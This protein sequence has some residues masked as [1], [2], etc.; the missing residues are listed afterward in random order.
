MVKRK[1]KNDHEKQEGSKGRGRPT[2]KQEKLIKDAMRRAGVQGTVKQRTLTIGLETIW[3]RCDDEGQLLFERIQETVTWV[4]RAV[5]LMT[6]FGNWLVLDILR[7]QGDLP[8]LDARW[9]LDLL[10]AITTSH[11]P[12]GLHFARFCQA[13]GQAALPW[14]VNTS[15]IMEYKRN[16]MLTASKNMLSG[17]FFWRRLSFLRWKVADALSGRFPD[18]TIAKR[19]TLLFKTTSLIISGAGEEANDYQCIMDLNPGDIPTLQEIAVDDHARVASLRSFISSRV[20][21]SW[22]KDRL[23]AKTKKRLTSDELRAR[24]RSFSISTL[25]DM[26]PMAVLRYH[27][28]QFDSI[29]HLPLTRSFS[30]CTS[31]ADFKEKLPWMWKKLRP[32]SFSPLPFSS[33]KRQFIRIDAKVLEEA[34]RVPLREDVWWVENL[35]DVYK[36]GKKRLHQLKEYSI[37]SDPRTAEACLELLPP[38]ETTRPCLPGASFTTDG[39]S[40]H[41]SVFCFPSTIDHLDKL[42]EA[43]YTGV[44]V[45]KKREKV[46]LTRSRR[47]VHK[48]ESCLLPVDSL[49]EDTE[50]IGVDPGAVQ[51]AS[52][53]RFG[54]SELTLSRPELVSN[55]ISRG[56]SY[57]ESTYIK[58][59]A[60]DL[61]ARKEVR[62]REINQR[63]RWSLEQLNGVLKKSF[64]VN[65]LEAYARQRVLSDPGL[66]EELLD[67][68]RSFHRR[69]RFIKTQQ[70]LEHMT[71][72]ILGESSRY[73]RQ[74]MRRQGIDLNLN[75]VVFFGRALFSGTKGHVTVPRKKLIRTLACK[76]TVVLV[77][78]YNTSKL[79]PYDFA[80]LEDGYEKRVRLCQTEFHQ[81]PFSCDR[82]VIGAANIAQKAIFELLGARLEAFYSS[83]QA[84]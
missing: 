14:M 44:K 7:S 64:D 27:V 29:Q 53:T 48:L 79:C 3:N 56:G 54:A 33:T 10:H 40:L 63:Y 46:D 26:D 28:D 30:N 57:S 41:L 42:H 70:C 62:R 37:L 52:Y 78:E 15:R 39:V 1:R 31:G 47:G 61:Q 55:M 19:N 67:R 24:F 32:P 5:A 76:A 74:K 66:Q 22:V 17:Q 65:V 34:W 4:S 16:E 8:V 72:K 84:A 20:E 13:T 21:E 6:L 35:V 25:V 71:H 68:T 23:G 12:F 11:G 77:N 36:G 73:K 58:N 51:V 50:F 75:K 83:E 9:F 45:L 81:G 38:D 82:D 49:N 69:L 60:R 18:L 2:P 59:T 43:G 80:I